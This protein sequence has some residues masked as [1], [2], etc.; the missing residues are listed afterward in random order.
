MASVLGEVISVELI[1]QV[2]LGVLQLVLELKCKGCIVF[3]LPSQGILR[4]EISSIMGRKSES[5]LPTSRKV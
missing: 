3:F 4:K 5:S 2:V 1:F